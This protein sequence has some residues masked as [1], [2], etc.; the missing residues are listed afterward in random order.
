VSGRERS[1][2][3]ACLD[4]DLRYLYSGEARSRSLSQV[5]AMSY[6]NESPF[7]KMALK[8]LKPDIARGNSFK[9]VSA[10]TR[11]L[12]CPVEGCTGRFAE[13]KEV[14]R[15]VR[16]T[17]SA[18]VRPPIQVV[19]G[20]NPSGVRRECA[21]SDGAGGRAQRRSPITDVDS[22]R[23]KITET[24]ALSCP[25]P[26]C[27]RVFKTPGWLARHIKSNHAVPADAANSDLPPAQMVGA[28]EPELPPQPSPTPM[29]RGRGM[30]GVDSGDGRGP[31]LVVGP[32]LRPRNHNPVPLIGDN[33]Y[34]HLGRQSRSR[35][36]GTQGDA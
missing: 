20:T 3:L 22:I 10:R 29:G 14:K 7:A 32:G 8:A 18:P 36:P 12:L 19:E 34:G 16:N 35:R 15:H 17:H 33:E 26:T 27:S 25:V 23:K 11:D 28:A 1:S 13:Q 9:L 24:A 21:G 30:A 31:V 2:F 5:I 6:E 4:M